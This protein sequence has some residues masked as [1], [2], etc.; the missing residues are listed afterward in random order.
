MQNKYYATHD[1]DGVSIA[2]NAEI[3]AF[4][5]KE[6]MVVFLK[7][8]YP[9][10]NGWNPES[11]VIESGWFGDCWI[12]H[13]KYKELKEY[14][15]APFDLDQVTIREPGTHPGNSEYRWI[16][17]NPEVMIVSSVRE[18]GQEDQE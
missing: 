1:N 5:T 7:S 18:K 17:P 8:G 12:K 6:E 14:V 13:P 11:I 4:D 3:Y 16:S 10:V 15:V 2:Q 9:E